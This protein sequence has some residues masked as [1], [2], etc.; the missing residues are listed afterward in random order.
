MKRLEELN[1]DR[2]DEVQLRRWAVVLGVDDLLA[3]VLRAVDITTSSLQDR[4]MLPQL[5][6]AVHQPAS[7]RGESRDHPRRFQNALVRPI[8]LSSASVSSS[9]CRRQS[10]FTLF[11]YQPSASRHVCSGVMVAPRG[12]S[13]VAHH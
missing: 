1:R 2:L 3:R 6:C 10:G 11:L 12:R 5:R 8:E 9:V 13:R 7:L 4:P